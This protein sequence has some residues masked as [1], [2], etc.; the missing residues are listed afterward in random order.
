MGLRSRVIISTASTD[1]D[2]LGAALALQ[3]ELLLQ[4]PHGA[5][6]LLDLAEAAVRS[7]A[8]R[9]LKEPAD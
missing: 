2:L 1:P 3:P 8:P 6:I 5:A 9:K 4:K 7:V